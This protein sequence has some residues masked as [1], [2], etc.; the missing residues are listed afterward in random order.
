MA[1]R[2]KKLFSLPNP[3]YSIGCPLIVAAGNL[4]MDSDTNRLI[5][6]LKLKN[7][8]AKTVSAAKVL[9]TAFE[10]NGVTI[11]KACE[12]QYLDLKV[13]RDQEFGHKTAIR[14]EYSAARSYSAAVTE[15]VFADGEVW[16]ATS[17]E[18]VNIPV[19]QDIRTYFSGNDDL[20][21]QYKIENG[22]RSDYAPISLADLWFCTCGAINH[23]DENS[24]HDCGLT[25]D[26]LLLN[27]DKDHLRQ[28]VAERKEKEAAEQEARQAAEVA[29]RTANKKRTLRI[30]G[31]GVLICAAVAG[32]MVYTNIIAPKMKYN[33][34]LEA[35][36]NGAYAEALAAFEDLGDYED[37]VDRKV[38]AYLGLASDSFESGDYETA[39][40]YY[41]LAD[42]DDVKE[43]LKS[44]NYQMMLAAVEVKDWPTAEEQYKLTQGYQDA[45]DYLDLIYIGLAEDLIADGEY[46]T[47]LENLEKCSDRVIDQLGQ[48]YLGI[49]VGLVEEGD[50]E[51]ALVAL[52]RCQEDAED[53][54]ALKDSCNY[55]LGV[56]A[57]EAGDYINT[58]KIL[59][60]FLEHETYGSDAKEYYYLSAK[61]LYESGDKELA[62][63]QFENIRD[64][65]DAT[66]YLP[67]K[68]STTTIMQD[69]DLQ[70]VFQQLQGK[71]IL[72]PEDYYPD[73]IEEYFTVSGNVRTEISRGIAFDGS[74]YTHT[75]TGKF[76]LIKDPVG[77]IFYGN[78]N[79]R[80]VYS[81][82]HETS[83]SGVG[84][85]Y[86]ITSIS[87]TELLLA[88]TWHYYKA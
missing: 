44:C 1:E 35:L 29:K 69:P 59:V 17:Q 80:V 12:Y 25:Y 68:T 2:L 75:G 40:E 72:N 14:L 77:I 18:L 65:R 61:E 23:D 54:I 48:Q 71:W 41:T 24:C 28:Q 66:D 81:D 84:F 36:E 11:E 79:N 78:E 26:T 67:K 4:L 15:V 52:G 87:D 64:Y 43:Q 82:G 57:Y 27:L 58:A 62:V 32:V 76:N 60:N 21:E 33:G 8:S 20:A 83:A 31:I 74:I 10:A 19:Q 86:V 22:K 39:I 9:I 5:V 63:K 70:R 34:A 88:N 16:K 56:A 46:V 53:V 73:T 49:A 13:L 45:D 38:A 30:A 47:A 51:N 3:L 7:I 6:Q 85:E 55:N 37:C 42:T 50:Y